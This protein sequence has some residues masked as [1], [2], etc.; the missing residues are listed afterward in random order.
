MGP[1]K[2]VEL[3]A[4]VSTHAFCSLQGLVFEVFNP[5]NKPKFCQKQPR[6][7]EAARNSDEGRK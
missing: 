6:N 1:L 5:Q 4:W 3:K 2:F 7:P